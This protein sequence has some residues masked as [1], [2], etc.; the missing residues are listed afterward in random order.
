[1]D[2]GISPLWSSKIEDGAF[3]TDLITRFSIDRELKWKPLIAAIKNAQ[4]IDLLEKRQ[5]IVHVNIHVRDD[6]RPIRLNG[7]TSVG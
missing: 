7:T 6:V 1:M 3:F 2:S 5:Q 4:D